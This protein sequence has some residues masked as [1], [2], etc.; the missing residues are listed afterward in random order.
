LFAWKSMSI[1]WFHFFG[2]VADNFLNEAMIDTLRAQIACQGVSKRVPPVEY[3][4]IAVGNGTSEIHCCQPWADIRP[5]LRANRPSSA[6]CSMNQSFMISA[7]AGVIGTFVHVYVV[8]RLLFTSRIETLPPSKS[9]SSRSDRNISPR[10]APVNAAK[11]DM[12]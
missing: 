7:S 10:L 8:V 9:Q 3:M 1:L 4:P 2:F 6:G 5:A 11:A 12:G